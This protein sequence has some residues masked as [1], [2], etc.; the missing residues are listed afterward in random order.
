MPRKSLFCVKKQA[1]ATA[2]FANTKWPPREGA[3][4]L[5]SLAHSVFSRGIT[6]Y[7]L[8]PTVY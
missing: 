8:L 3:T 4:N 2:A 1:K 5:V 6:V 7:C